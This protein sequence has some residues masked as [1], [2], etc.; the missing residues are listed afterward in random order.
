MT[1]QCRKCGTILNDGNWAPSFQEKYDYIC[2]SCMLEV[3]RS[4][5]ERNPEKKM[6]ADRRRRKEH[7]EKARL[8]SEIDNR[9]R[10]V[11]PL[12]ENTACSSFLGIHVAEGLLYR[13]FNDVEVMP[14][15]N[16]GYDFTCNKG[17]IDCNISCQRNDRRWVSWKFNIRRN[18]V[19]DYFICLALDNRNDMNLLHIWLLPGNEFNH[20]QVASISQGT[21]RKWDAYRINVEKVSACCDVL[22]TVE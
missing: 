11:L 7:P 5:R 19:A 17:M 10:G 9:R 22:K 20:L 16:V 18:V 12:N 14:M 13:V 1:H 3:G 15:N 6:V 21:V 2:K 8:K 4:W